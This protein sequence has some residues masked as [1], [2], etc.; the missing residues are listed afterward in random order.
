MPLFFPLDLYHEVFWCKRWVYFLLKVLKADIS[1]NP[2][3]LLSFLMIF[4]DINLNLFIRSPLHL[5][6]LPIKL[7]FPNL[8]IVHLLIILLFHLLWYILSWLF[9]FHLHVYIIILILRL[10]KWEEFIIKWQY[11]LQKYLKYKF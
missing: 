11:W 10:N 9:L 3:S 2:Q 5:N 4:K 8:S 1:P 6:Y 7:V